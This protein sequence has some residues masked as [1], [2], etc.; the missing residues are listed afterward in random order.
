MNCTVWGSL[1]KDT[2]SKT[3][4]EVSILSYSVLLT[5]GLLIR[6]SYIMGGV[7][8]EWWNSHMPENL[9]CPAMS[10]M[11]LQ[12]L[13]HLQKAIITEASHPACFQKKKKKENGDYSKIKKVKI[14]LDFLPSGN[15]I[16][17]L[18]A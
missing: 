18:L 1:E 3:I 9:M 5:G 12:M 16:N 11:A 10:G 15:K 14:H 17:S 4:S 6:L 7:T 2:P 13:S 8:M